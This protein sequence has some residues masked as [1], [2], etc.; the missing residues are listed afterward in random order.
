MNRKKL[1]KIAAITLIT[2]ITSTGLYGCG[3][4]KESTQTNSETTVT[5]DVQ[6]EPNLNTQEESTAEE[7]IVKGDKISILGEASTYVTYIKTGSNVATIRGFI[8][9]KLKSNV[10]AGSW[11]IFPSDIKLFDLELPDT[12]NKNAEGFRN[13]FTCNYVANTFKSSETTY[14]SFMFECKVPFNSYEDSDEWGKSVNESMLKLYSEEDVLK[15]LEENYMEA[16]VCP[17]TVELADTDVTRGLGIEQSGMV[18]TVVS[19][20]LTNETSEDIYLDGENVGIG[21]RALL[22]DKEGKIICSVWLLT[23]ETEFKPGQHLHLNT[24][25]A[26]NTYVNYEDIDLHNSEILEVSTFDLRE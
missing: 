3:T 7:K 9:Y 22:R 4:K 18:N 6:K 2:L 24:L 12:M 10:K 13:E 16:A 1:K 8:T 5:T 15:K 23:E 21:A 17:K 14:A 26:I 11:V 25:E 19:I 20:V